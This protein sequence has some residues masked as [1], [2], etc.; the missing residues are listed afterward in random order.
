MFDKAIDNKHSLHHD[1][2]KWTIFN[3]LFPSD[4]NVAIREPHNIL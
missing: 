4:W 1:N 2:K 3:K